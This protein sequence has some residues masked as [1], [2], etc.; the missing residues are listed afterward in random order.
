MHTR[1]DTKMRIQA[2]LD[3]LRNPGRSMSMT[4][5]GENMGRF[6]GKNFSAYVK[7]R[8]LSMLT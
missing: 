3:R 4:L 1:N 2:I 5:K 8:L 6:K 7:Y